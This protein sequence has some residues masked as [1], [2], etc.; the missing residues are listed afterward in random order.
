MQLENDRIYNR[1][2]SIKS[3]LS[4]SN[5][6]NCSSAVLMSKSAVLAH[7]SSQPRWTKWAGFNNTNKENMTSKDLMKSSS[8]AVLKTDHSYKDER[9]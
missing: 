7:S 2:K 4:P 9:Y 1:I 3:T 5:P 8:Q 6:K